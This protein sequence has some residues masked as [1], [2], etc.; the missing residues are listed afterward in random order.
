MR[1]VPTWTDIKDHARSSYKLAEE[2]PHNFKV[3]FGYPGGRLQAVI[4]AHYEAMGR[5][6]IDFSSACCRADRLDPRAAL[7]QSFNLAVGSL[8]LDGEVYVVR[9]TVNA[10]QLDLADLE[11]HLHAV[12]RAADQ[13][14][15]SLPM[16]EPASGVTSAVDE[17]RA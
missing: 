17:E 1:P 15:Q 5:A 2:H 4:A 3:V 10:D 9:H 6:W 14:E 7:R 8:C 13:I 11:L 12:A 16:Y